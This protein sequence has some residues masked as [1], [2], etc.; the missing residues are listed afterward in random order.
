MEGGKQKWEVGMLGATTTGLDTGSATTGL[1]LG[2]VK[3]RGEAMQEAKARHPVE[4]HC[5]LRP[6]WIR[7][8]LWTCAYGS[9]FIAT[10][11]HYT[12]VRPSLRIPRTSFRLHDLNDGY[13]NRHE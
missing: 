5:L 4:T 12:P 9:S 7:I 3:E 1:D 6:T 8:R 11:H 13:A 10:D 2:K